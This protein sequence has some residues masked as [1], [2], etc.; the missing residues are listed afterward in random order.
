MKKK[1][2]NAA[3]SK[4]M[5]GLL[6]YHVPPEGSFDVVVVVVVLF[7]IDGRKQKTHSFSPESLGQYQPWTRAD[8]VCPLCNPPRFMFPPRVHFDNDGRARRWDFER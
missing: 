8:A 1:S 3:D 7:F 5:P 2:V 4:E 6:S